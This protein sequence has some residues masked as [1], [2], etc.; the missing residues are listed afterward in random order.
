MFLYLVFMWPHLYAGKII[1]MTNDLIKTETWFF[2]H[3]M[4]E[5][6]ISKK[7]ND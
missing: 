4:L 7:E 5:M 1:K 3:F 6:K 2:R